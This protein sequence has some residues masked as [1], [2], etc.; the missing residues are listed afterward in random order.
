MCETRECPVCND[1]RM[2][3]V[4]KTHADKDMDCG[5]GMQC[6][7]CGFVNDGVPRDQDTLDFL[8]RA[9]EIRKAGNLAFD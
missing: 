2:Q 8:R 9:Y 7:K 6:S 3:C 5:N 1:G 4:Y